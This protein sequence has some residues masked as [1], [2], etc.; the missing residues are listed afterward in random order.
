MLA[1]LG[2][3]QLEAVRL[4]FFDGLSHVEIAGK[5]GIPL[6]TIKSRIRT[7]MMR[8]RELLELQ[9]EAL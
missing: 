5:T 8:M 7:G 3:E 4:A 9:M 2:P 1:G 6:G